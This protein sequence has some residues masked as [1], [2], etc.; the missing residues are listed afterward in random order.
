MYIE[1]KNLT[2]PGKKKKRKRE[3]ER[4]KGFFVSAFVFV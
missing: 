2:V 1:K 4:C 3:T